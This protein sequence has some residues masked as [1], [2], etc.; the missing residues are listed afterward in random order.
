M[1][2]AR[3][4]VRMLVVPCALILASTAQAQNAGDES[5]EIICVSVA[6]M[7]GG[8]SDDVAHISSV[9]VPESYRRL[10]FGDPCTR[11]SLVKSSLI[12][13]N[14]AFG[15]E[16]STTAALEF[17]EAQ[18][19]A[20]KPVIA[21][22][23]QRL[24]AARRDA[25]HD[26]VAAATI[27]RQPDG[28]QRGGA[29][30]RKSKSLERLRSM[31]DVRN[32]YTFL[33]GQYLRAAEFYGSPGLLARA[34]RY[35]A[36]AL[37]AMRITRAL[38]AA[39]VAAKLDGVSPLES[40]DYRDLDA[41]DLEMRMAVVSASLSSDPEDLAA[42][43]TVLA[44]YDEPFYKVAASEAFDHGDGFCDIGER[45]DLADYAKACESGD[46]DKK[47]ITWW[48][49]RAQLDLLGT[50]PP[51]L[52][53]SFYTA[54]HLIERD[55]AAHNSQQYRPRYDTAADQIVTLHLACAEAFIRS[56]NPNPWAS[57]ATNSNAAIQSLDAALNELSLA[58]RSAPAS[59][60]PGRFRQIATRFLSIRAR[61][62]ALEKPGRYPGLERQAAYFSA[63]LA[64]LD[65]IALGRAAK[66]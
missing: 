16:A 30:V 52:L 63:V 64:S 35:A 61:L 24:A 34:R 11:F 28:M 5:G 4:L 26:I 65:D 13:W 57:S 36:P 41:S 47:A 9:P 37:D 44:S 33:A 50:G 31:I 19:T 39:D 49:Y 51:D 53:D 23:G 29:L 8:T 3:Y 60:T 25:Q 18:T 20:G 1:V 6:Q 42:A 66:Q 55:Y 59:Q 15:N 45:S 43:E 12:D 32:D 58:E 10:Y 14:L 62:A 27:L 48:R 56:A 2:I 7:W 46:F 17:L 54:T 38:A 21:D 40:G 22:L